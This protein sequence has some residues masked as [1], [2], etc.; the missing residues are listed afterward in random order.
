MRIKRKLQAC[1]RII[2][3]G[4]Y[5][6]K[7]LLLEEHKIL[8]SLLDTPLSCENCSELVKKIKENQVYKL[9]KLDKDPDF[10]KSFLTKGSNANILKVLLTTTDL[11]YSEQEKNTL[12]KYFSIF[13]LL[14]N[15]ETELRK[16][17]SLV[18]ELILKDGEEDFFAKHFQELAR[19]NEIFL[20]ETIDKNHIEWFFDTDIFN[21]I[22]ADPE[23]FSVKLSDIYDFLIQDI[24]LYTKKD[25]NR[26]C[27]IL[28]D[29]KTKE[30]NDFNFNNFYTVLCDKRQKF[31]ERSPAFS[32]SFYQSREP[33][34]S[35][36]SLLQQS[37][38]NRQKKFK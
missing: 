4:V 28:L 15:L 9:F 21:L 33:H 22:A 14:S 5:P 13:V 6:N 37:I 7:N 1:F 2:N 36:N 24:N 26:Q 8:L 19:L 38:N 31:K 23:N 3:I 16:V 17:V 30:G 10:L 29:K 35:G 25:F 12:E 32:A 34:K 27:Q 18:S 11:V 20:F